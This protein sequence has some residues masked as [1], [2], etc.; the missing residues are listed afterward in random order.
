[1]FWRTF[2][3]SYQA[4]EFNSLCFNSV[5]LLCFNFVRCMVI[6]VGFNRTAA[7][8]VGFRCEGLLAFFSC[9]VATVDL[10]LSTAV[11]VFSVVISYLQQS[12]N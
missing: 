5:C 1:M 9:L 10:L 3:G 8:F 7:L 4:F 11:A 2:G 12:S 6:F